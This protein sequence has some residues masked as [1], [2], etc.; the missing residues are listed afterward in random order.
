MNTKELNENL[1]I[2]KIPKDAYSLHGGFPNESFCIGEVN[3]KW[4]TY[5][6]ERGCKTGLKSFTNENEACD[7][8]LTW[9]KRI[10]KK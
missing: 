6:G 3:G 10:F 5:Y 7:Y 1:Q 2:L 9:M 4:E 8:F